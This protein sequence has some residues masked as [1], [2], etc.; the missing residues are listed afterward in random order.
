[1]GGAP[2]NEQ[3]ILGILQEQAKPLIEISKFIFIS[4]YKNAAD[5]TI[6]KEYNIKYVLNVAGPST[7]TDRKLLEDNEIEYM[8]INAIDEED[9]PI[10]QNYWSRCRQFM[11]KAQTREK[12]CLV[13]CIQGMNRSAVIVAAHFLLLAD[14]AT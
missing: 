2:L 12:R 6:L 14:H 11:I 10:I 1:M 4:D 8:E 13:H 3:D 5:I 9:Y 7:Q